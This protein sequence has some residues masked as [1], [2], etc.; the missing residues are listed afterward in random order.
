MQATLFAFVLIFCFVLQSFCVKV[1]AKA[2]MISCEDLPRLFNGNEEGRI[3][4][5]V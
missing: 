2:E 4:G 1:T 5:I 3:L